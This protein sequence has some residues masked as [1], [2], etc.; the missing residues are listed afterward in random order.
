MHRLFIL[1]SLALLF[2]TSAAWAQQNVVKDKAVVV[3]NWGGPF[4][5]GHLIYRADKNDPVDK[6]AIFRISLAYRDKNP[7]VS[8]YA[9][10]GI[11]VIMSLGNEDKKA[12]TAD[13]MKGYE[14]LS[15]G[16]ET[17]V[18]CKTRSEDLKEAMVTVRVG[19]EVFLETTR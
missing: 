19:G 1:G 6:G 3:D 4:D 11:C 13:L 8:V 9:R 18:I 16:P 7:A 10:N 5:K 14:L 12:V 17:T 15:R 2:I